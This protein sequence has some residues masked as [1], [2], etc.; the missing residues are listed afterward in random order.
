M[1]TELD[2]VD[3]VERRVERAYAVYHLEEVV[4]VDDVFLVHLYEVGMERE[5]HL[6]VD[7]AFQPNG[8][9]PFVDDDFPAP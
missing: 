5:E 4:E 6:A 3:F 2:E 1:A 8:F 9:L 7:V